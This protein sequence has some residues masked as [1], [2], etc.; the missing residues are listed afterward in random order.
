MSNPTAIVT[1]GSIRR[2]LSEGIRALVTDA[3]KYPQLPPQKNDIFTMFDSKKAYELDVGLAG[4]GLA[5]LKPE[6]AAIEYDGEQQT[7]A[8]V[9]THA[10]HALG[11]IITMEAL[12]DNLYQ[13]M[14]ERSSNMLVRSINHTQEHLAARIINNAYTTTILGDGQPLFSQAHPPR[15]RISSG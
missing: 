13:E 12:S 3:L 11:V 4:T 15:V 10:V 9:Y 6:G 7:F 1:S 2:L 8:T 5:A 14:I